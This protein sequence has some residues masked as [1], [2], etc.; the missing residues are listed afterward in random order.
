[1]CTANTIDTE[2]LLTH[3]TKL[4]QKE[5]VHWISVRGYALSS[6]FK[7]WPET[8]TLVQLARSGIR[9]LRGGGGLGGCGGG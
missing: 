1:M 2:T 4:K 7:L 5:F 3:T 8:R 9:S 6:P